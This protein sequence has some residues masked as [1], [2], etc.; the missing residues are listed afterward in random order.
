MTAV[1]GRR[2]TA[3]LLLLAVT[4]C[5]PMEP[6]ETDERIVTVEP[7]LSVIVRGTTLIALHAG[8]GKRLWEYRRELRPQPEYGQHPRPFVRC[9]VGR[10]KRN[11][12]VVA[13]SDVI[14]ALTAAE[15]ERA[16]KIRNRDPKVCPVITPDSAVVTTVPRPHSSGALLKHGPPDG[17]QRWKLEPPDIGRLRDVSVEPSTGDVIARSGTHAISVNPEGQVNWVRSLRELGGEDGR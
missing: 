8:N 12:L 5:E 10:T 13:Y 3:A 4:A 17:E 16:W 7:N 9:I 1:L 2:L 15:G 14:V 6:R 11:D